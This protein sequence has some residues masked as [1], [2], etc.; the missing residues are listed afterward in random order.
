MDF[1]LQYL[2]F[3]FPSPSDFGFSDFLSWLDFYA[4]HLSG[5]ALCLTSLSFPQRGGEL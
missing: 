3:F 4:V 5:H 1:N 2:L